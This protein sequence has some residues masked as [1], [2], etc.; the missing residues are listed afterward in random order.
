MPV[1]KKFALGETQICLQV[2]TDDK[3]SLSE[4]YSVDVVPTM[5]FFENEKA[6]KRLDGTPEWG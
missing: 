4:K 1:F 5:P 2:K 3:A 6:V